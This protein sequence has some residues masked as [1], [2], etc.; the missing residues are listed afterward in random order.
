MNATR[1]ALPRVAASA[2]VA[3]IS[4][5]LVLWSPWSAAANASEDTITWAVAPADDAGPDGRARIDLSLDPGASVT[6]HLAVRNLSAQDATFSLSAAD[7]YYTT[8]GRFNMLASTEK[9]TDAGTWITVA[10]NVE[11]KAGETAIVPFTV[12]VPLN[13]TPGDHAAGIAA[14][15][16]STGTD[17][18]G[19]QI[20]VES[21]VGFRVTTRVAGELA[22]ALNLS[23]L[24]A[25]YTTSWSL[26]QPGE[27]TVA[28]NARNAGNTTLT[29]V[30][31]VNQVSTEQGAL[32]PGEERK[33]TVTD[34]AA[35]PIG[36]LVVDVVVEGL[37]PGEDLAITP[38]TQ[39]MIVWAM[40]W[41]HLLCVLAVAL[42]VFALLMGRR[43]SRRRVDGLVAQAREDGRREAEI[44]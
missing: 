4:A 31:D 2:A 26:L 41:P 29:V 19:T 42:I 5:V 24:T 39:Q 28:Y 30:D 11:V 23:G 6:E 15:V 16:Q 13:A 20:G 10:P 44:A 32:L 34:V 3:A 38:R 27:L 8:N 35:W 36:I 9:S 43:R 25:S 12:A 18:D 7:G 17:E 21:R 14:S 1:S 37:V 33:L 40:P 22:P